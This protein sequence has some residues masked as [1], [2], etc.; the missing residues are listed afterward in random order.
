MRGA[1][2]PSDAARRKRRERNSPSMRTWRSTVVAES[3]NSTKVATT[4]PATS[5]TTPPNTAN[6]RATSQ[7][8]TQV[9]RA[10]RAYWLDHIRPGTCS[11]PASTNPPARQA[12]GTQCNH[13][14]PVSATPSM[15]AACQRIA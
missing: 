1:I 14:A 2:H 12:M 8:C 10:W 9:K 3:C 4:S 15:M 5:A 6:T 11:N 7:L 13:Q